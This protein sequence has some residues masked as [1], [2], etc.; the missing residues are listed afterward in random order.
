MD[1]KPLD[2]A[3]LSFIDLIQV[4][5]GQI[6]ASAT[7]GILMRT[8]ISAAERF[9]PVAFATFDDFV[10][11]I[12]DV[13]NPIALFEGKAKR[14]DAGLFG[15]P[16]CPFAESIGNYKTIF[17][18]LPEGFK[19]ITEE[20]NQPGGMADKLRIGNGAGVSPFCAAHQS[21]RAA[22]GNKVTIGGRHAVIHQL[23]CK[24]SA[25]AKGF[26]DRWIRAAGY[27]QEQ[28]SAVLD[29]AMCCYDVRA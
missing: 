4:L 2:A 20:F 26:A 28:V 22:L 7:K 29:D 1:T 16:Q 5:A 3:H 12:E 25:G 19:A 24:S 6:G 8:A 9:E 18:K 17:K 13:G 23:G 11:S 14:I 10:R 27:S 15:L 21:I